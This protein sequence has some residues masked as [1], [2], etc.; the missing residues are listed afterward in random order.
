MFPVIKVVTLMK[1]QNQY[2]SAGMLSKSILRKRYTLER[3][4]HE[5]SGFFEGH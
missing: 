2:T 3:V 4:M 5:I 1:S